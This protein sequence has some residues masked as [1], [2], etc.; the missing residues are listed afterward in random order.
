MLDLPTSKV[1]EK[2][3]KYPARKVF[4]NNGWYNCELHTKRWSVGLPLKSGKPDYPVGMY[5]R[6]D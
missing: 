3:N 5:C 2:A 1:K 4:L 6:F